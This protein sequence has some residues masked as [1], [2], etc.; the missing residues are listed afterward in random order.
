MVAITRAVNVQYIKMTA[1]TK[2]TTATTQKKYNPHTVHK[3]N[4]FSSFA[5]IFFSKKN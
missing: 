5:T 1:T 4:P 3:K 2:T